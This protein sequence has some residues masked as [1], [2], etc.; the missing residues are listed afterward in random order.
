VVLSLWNVLVNLRCP[1]LRVTLY[2]LDMWD[3]GI[4]NKDVSFTEGFLHFLLGA[5]I[6]YIE[7]LIPIYRDILSLFKPDLW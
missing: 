5:L 6:F 4:E 3:L 2:R 7:M 1:S